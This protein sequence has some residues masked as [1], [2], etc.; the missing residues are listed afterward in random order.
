LGHDEE[1]PAGSPRIGPR[2]AP[3]ILASA[4][5]SIARQY[6]P[7]EGGFGGAPKFPPS[8]RLELLLR[9]SLRRRT[10]RAETREMVERTL[11]KMAAG[12]MYDQ[13]GGGFHRYSV[14]AHWLVPHFE[15]M[16]Y[17][18]AMLARVYVLASRAFG[19]PD[20]ADVARDTLDYL[21]REMT[22][23][24]GGFYAAQDAD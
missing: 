17:D 18:N 3:E 20:Y 6:D 4:M 1:T 12:G 10:G 14:D 5:R 11:R 9:D 8:M 15:K 7:V 19:E 2:D 23:E 13:V 16:L 24:G 22:P 21:L